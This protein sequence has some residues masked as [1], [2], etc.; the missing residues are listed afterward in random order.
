M[1]AKKVE[2]DALEVMKKVKQI[3][4]LLKELRDL[5]VCVKLSG[6]NGK[7]GYSI[8]IKSI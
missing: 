5:G 4:N 7:K 3:F 2:A 6:G 8:D 1:E